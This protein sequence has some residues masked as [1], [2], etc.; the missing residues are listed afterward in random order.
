MSA[1]EIIYSTS[2][3]NIV[4][5]MKS[6]NM[7]M[8]QMWETIIFSLRIFIMAENFVKGKFMQKP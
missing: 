5:G 3:F 2:N 4:S 6:F 7:F 8:W 1:N